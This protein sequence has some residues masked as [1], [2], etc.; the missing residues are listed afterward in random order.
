[1]SSEDIDGDA[2]SPDSESVSGHN[3]STTRLPAD[4]A[5]RLP[6]EPASFRSDHARSSGSQYRW[7]ALALAAL[8]LGI[9]LAGILFPDTRD[10]LFTLAAVGLFGGFL[11]YYLSS[12]QYLSVTVGES[13]YA[14]SASNGAAIVD[15]FDLKADHIYAPTGP[16]A[17]LHRARLVIPVRSGGHVPEELA[18]RSEDGG[19]GLVLEPTGYGL[20]RE[21]ERMLSG[22]LAT[23]PAPLAAALADGLV[24][25]LDLAREVK[26]TV[27][28]ADGRM[29]FEISG[30][31]LAPL[32]RFDHPI[33]SFIGV[34]LAVG[35]DRPI[36]LEVDS[37]DGRAEW[38]VTCRWEIDDA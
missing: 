14:A 15:A 6:E 12:G 34:G 32:D 33:P 18:V 29:T 5:E 26:P 20:F 24:E 38:L 16:N 13:I 4:H 31:S 22:D 30:G 37:S 11:T 10:V 21:F 35:L 19:N 27:D 28:S 25:G 2:S 1:M 8:G 17:D 9:G 7:T 3:L 36:E 23:T